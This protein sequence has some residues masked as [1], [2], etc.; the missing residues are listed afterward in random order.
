[1]S[2]K[3]EIIQNTRKRR[4]NALARIQQ[5]RGALQQIIQDLKEKHGFKSLKA[6][7]QW[8]AKAGERLEELARKRDQRA[9]KFESTFGTKLD[10]LGS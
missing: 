4:E 8:L 1:M 2:D 9:R 10:D 7:K 5:D 6:A 3:A